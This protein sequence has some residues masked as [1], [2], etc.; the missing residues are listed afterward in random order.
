MKRRD[1]PFNL[2]NVTKRNQ[3]CPHNPLREESNWL[4][5]HKYRNMKTIPISHT[6]EKRHAF[7]FIY[8]K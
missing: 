6:N 5:F 8:I 7:P 1:M 3:L 4:P 2:C